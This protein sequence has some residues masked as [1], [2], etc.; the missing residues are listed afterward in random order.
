MQKLRKLGE[1]KD[2]GMLSEEEFSA[3]KSKILK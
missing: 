1:L 2:K 3:A